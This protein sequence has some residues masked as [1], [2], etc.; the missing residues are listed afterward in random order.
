MYSGSDFCRN[1]FWPQRGRGR[2]TPVMQ[3]RA[4]LSSCWNFC[5]S[6][7]L[8]AFSFYLFPHAELSNLTLEV[9][10][11]WGRAWTTWSTG[12]FSKLNYSLILWNYLETRVT[13]LGLTRGTGSDG[14][15]FPEPVGGWAGRG[16][17]E[18]ELP[19]L[20]GIPIPPAMLGTGHPVPHPA[21]ALRSKVGG[22]TPQELWQLG[23]SELRVPRANCEPVQRYRCLRIREA[24]GSK[25]TP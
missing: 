15:T 10:V 3:P 12:I 20:M 1:G 23:L 5:S 22:P 17:H 2:E 11:L 4:V 25:F 24:P 19:I 21:W 13:A 9:A 6:W 16:L 14:S 7:R 8:G 18:E